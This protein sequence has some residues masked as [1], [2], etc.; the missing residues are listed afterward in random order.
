MYKQLL[1]LQGETNAYMHIYSYIHK[2]ISHT[3]FQWP[4]QPLFGPGPFLSSVII[5]TQTVGPSQ[6]RYLDTGQYKHRI[7]AYTNIHAFNGIRT[8]D[9]NVRAREDSLCPRPRSHCDRQNTIILHT[10]IYRIGRQTRSSWK[11]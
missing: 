2:Y 3:F 11:K 9:P 5:F 4:L 1:R 8:H 6:G 10:Y 7:N